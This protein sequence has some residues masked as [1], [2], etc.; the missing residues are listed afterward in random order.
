MGFSCKF[1]L[2]LK[3]CNLL[4]TWRSARNEGFAIQSSPSLNEETESSPNICFGGSQDPQKKH[5]KTTQ[6]GE[7]R[8]KTTIPQHRT[9][10]T[11]VTM[12]SQRGSQ[13]APHPPHPRHDAL[14]KT[15]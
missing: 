5:S 8:R 15:S 4:Q 14:R 6:Q 2:K 3:E 12:T 13:E 9:K 11:D 10:C 7:S 1:S